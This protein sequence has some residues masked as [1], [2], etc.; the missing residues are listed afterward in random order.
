[1]VLEIKF[2][3]NTIIYIYC[4]YIYTVVAK[5]I[6]TLVFSAAKNGFKSV[7]S[8][9]CCSVSEGNISSHFQTFI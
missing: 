2:N 5:I 9:F 7:I 3:W 8:I 1:M 4:I 6:K